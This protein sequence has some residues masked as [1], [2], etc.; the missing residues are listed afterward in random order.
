LMRDITLDGMIHYSPFSIGEY[1]FINVG[2]GAIVAFERL[3]NFEP[4]VKGILNYGGKAG[5]E[6]EI[7]VYTGLVLIGNSYQQ[8]LLK[9]T[10]GQKRIEYGLGFKI[11]IN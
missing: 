1:A 7:P 10:Y 2:A 6:I 4:A 9:K 11:L 5:I 3:T 8:F